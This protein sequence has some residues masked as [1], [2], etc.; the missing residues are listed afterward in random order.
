M[1]V[2]FWSNRRV[3]ITG[4]TGFKGS[5]L[6]ILLREAGAEVFGYALDPPTRPS[7]FELCG[8]SNLIASS[9]GDITDL[10]GVRAFVEDS[11]PEVIFHLA[12]QSLVR[13]AYVDPLA[14]FSTNVMGTVNVLEAARLT[15]SVRAVVNVTSDKCYENDLNVRPHTENDPMG[16]S[17]P[18]SASK[19]CAE[20]AAAAYA[21]TYFSALASVRAG[22]VIGGGDWGIDRLIPDC[23]RYLSAGEIIKVRN[24]LH[25]RP[26]QH[27]L[28][29]LSGYI[30][31]AEKLHEEGAA[32]G[33]GWN[34][35]PFSD[36]AVPVSAVVEAM[37]GLWGSG[38]WEVVGEQHNISESAYL[39]LDSSKARRLIGWRSRLDFNA[40]IKWTVEWYRR[41][42]AGDDADSL[43]AFT[44]DQIK[45]YQTL[46]V[47]V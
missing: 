3:L 21:K 20:L 40:A 31:V 1:N 41:A 14:T 2:D 30:A 8:L 37:V 36:R 44:L 12:A 32:W 33:G 17:E 38:S 22:N 39:A 47:S 6:S 13:A 11:Q 46:G 43:Y 5:W 27:V 45:D 28:D 24:P 25:V 9:H 26:W 35:G 23:V 42:L 16:G 4:H 19:G 7:M 15:P 10:A 18:Y 29:P 34:F